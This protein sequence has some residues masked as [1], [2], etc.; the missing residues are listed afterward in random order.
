MFLNRELEDT[1][2]RR[3]FLQTSAKGTFA[4]AFLPHFLNCAPKEMP[5]RVLG[6]T[7]VKLSILGFGGILV[8]DEAQKV[9]NE[10]VA[11]AFD[12]A[13]TT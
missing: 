13:S 8:M 3:D 6:L 10:M 11:R 12:H 4:M 9:A 1:M 2:K 5:K 7:G